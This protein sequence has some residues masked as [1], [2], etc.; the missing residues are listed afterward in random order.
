MRAA[1]DFGISNIDAVA[2]IDGQLQ[3]WTRASDGSP[4]A[5]LLRAVLAQAG[6]DLSRLGQ[7]AVTGGRHRA[8]PQRIGEC[9][10]IRVGE[11]QAIGR[12][13][14]ALAELT[15]EQRGGPLLVVS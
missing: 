5:V 11:V 1:I 13:G 3:R 9:T 15:N 2:R 6:L 4:D 7:V 8:L 14:Q 10:I 12:G